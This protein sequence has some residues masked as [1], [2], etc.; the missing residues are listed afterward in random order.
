MALA[1]TGAM[2]LATLFYSR[3]KRNCTKPNSSCTVT[4][5]DH[6]TKMTALEFQIRNQLLWGSFLFRLNGFDNGASSCGKIPYEQEPGY[7]SR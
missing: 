2:I 5:K 3:S 4:D 6:V 7:R 1:A